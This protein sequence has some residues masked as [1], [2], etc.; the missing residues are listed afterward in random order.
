MSISGI[1]AP[2]AAAYIPQ[3]PGTNPAT[4]PSTTFGAAAQTASTTPT[5]PVQ[6]AAPAQPSGPA[7][8][9]HHHGGGDTSGQSFD[10]TQ[11]RTNTVA[12]ILSTLV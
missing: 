1:S 2:S 4:T 3:A 12:N 10:V 11:S 7:H 9:H 8:R 6:Q 5:A